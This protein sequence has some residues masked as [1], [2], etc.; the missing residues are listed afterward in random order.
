MNKIDRFSS[1]LSERLSVVVREIIGMVEDIVSEYREETTRTKKENEIL[2]RQLRDFFLID[3]DTDA[4]EE[5]TTTQQ[6]E[7]SLGQQEPLINIT[8]QNLC[9]K[10]PESRVPASDHRAKPSREPDDPLSHSSTQPGKELGKRR[11]SVIWRPAQSNSS[12]SSH[13]GAASDLSEQE[14]SAESGDTCTPTDT[15]AGGKG[16]KRKPAEKASTCAGGPL[17]A[18]T[19]AGGPH[20]C[21]KCDKS[22]TE[23]K[24]LKSHHRLAHSKVMGC[25]ICGKAFAQT[26]D[27]QRHLL[28]HSGERPHQCDRCPRSFAQLG[29]LRKHQ[30]TH[31]SKQQHKCPHCNMGFNDPDALGQHDCGR[32]K[33]FC[34]NICRQCFSSA[35]SLQAHLRKTHPKAQTLGSKGKR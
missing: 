34:C 18:S 12:G 28:T 17:K 33:P 16:Q 8:L 9:Q 29:N 24:Y 23:L 7:G 15:G 30:Q 35:K 25:N 20:K 22:F 27:L 1:L 2:K 4:F 26:V 32:D 6:K 5:G 14:D 31:E 21:S 3:D 10:L 13:S 19:R 11:R